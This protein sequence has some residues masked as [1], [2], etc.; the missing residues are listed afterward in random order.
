PLQR[1]LALALLIVL[2]RTAVSAQTSAAAARAVTVPAKNGV[3][4]KATINGQGPFDAI[5]D[6]GSGNLMTVSLARRLGLKL[7]GS[8]TLNAGGGLV[9]AKVVKVATVNIG[10]LTMSDQW[11]GVVDVPVT[12]GQDG[13]FV[14]DL[15]LQN[16]PIRVDFE[17]QEI[18]FYSKQGFE[19]LGDGTAVPIHSKD[20]TLLAEATVDGIDGLFGID[21]GDMYS[22]SLY[23]PFVAQHKLVEHYGAK[24]Q[25]Y[26]GQG[27]GG[28]D[29]GFYT[30]ADTLQL[31]KIEVIHPITV[32]STDTQ[33]AES[34]ATVAGNIGL[35]VLRQF[36]IVFDAPHGKM[37]LEKNA[38]F[39][40]PDIFNRAGLML[41]PDPEN[42]KIKTVIPRSPGAR[43]GLK[44]EDVITQIDGKPPT[45]ESLQSA[46]TQ[47]IGTV[48]RLTVRHGA[49][50]R[51][52]SLVLKNIL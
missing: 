44:E 46:F 30:R 43:A 49:K 2:A 4:L 26:A 51:T 20:G 50:T 48:L 21:S 8:A 14:G 16:L 42:L 25:G 3:E 5:F 28:A 45:D 1:C 10:G 33:G 18:T 15:L 35:H 52:V 12:Q 22:L 37:Y 38:N 40:K 41:D 47:P 6:T 32:L 9:P 13:I 17:K 27:F 31:G 39:G 11:F 7:E 23:A 19:Y 24:I 36:N 34:S 29:H